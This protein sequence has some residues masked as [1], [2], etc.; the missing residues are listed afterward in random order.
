MKKHTLLITILFALFVSL[1]SVSIVFYKFYELNKKRYIDHIFSRYLLISE[2]YKDYQ[3]SGA[4]LATLEANLAVNNFELIKDK[5]EFSNV[6]R[7]AKE[8]KSKRTKTI[9][10]SVFFDK[11]GLF[12]KQLITDVTI[13]MLEYKNKIYFMFQTPAGNV[14]LEDNFVK[15]YSI[16]P[17]LYAYSTIFF[18]ISFSFFMILRK[19]SPL[20]HLRKKIEKLISGKITDVSFKTS[21]EDEIGAIANALEDAREK[22]ESMLE[23]R[24]LFLRNIMH[25]LKTPIAKGRL[26]AAMVKDE[27]QQKRFESIFIRLENL[28]NEFA[29]IEETNSIKD[30]S[31][32]NE[33]RLIDIIDGA[34]DMAMCD[35]EKV[36]VDVDASIKIKANFTQYATAI[37]NMIDNGIKYST[38]TRV[39]IVFEDNEL[40]FISKGECLKYPL[41]FY[42]EPF[43]KENPSKNSFG[44]GL[45]LVDSI[46]KAHNQILAHEYKDGYNIF[47]FANETKDAK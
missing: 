43:T 40:K 18:I 28:V 1:T 17:L 24:T 23:A 30:K 46:L 36:D 19:L 20:I 14:L 2:I 3:E 45:Y 29:M 42:I 44:L 41:K 38:D 15:P 10:E 26:A 25:E 37:K 12:K 5:K 8:L 9:S 35:R 6:V 13:Y 34:I 16:S 33:Y 7:F 39:K 31:K 11:N 4:S 22:I 21:R 47:I 27:K 32:H